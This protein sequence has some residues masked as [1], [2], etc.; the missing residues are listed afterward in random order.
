VKILIAEDDPVSS[1]VL[2]TTL[3]KWGHDV[4]T[5]DNGLNALAE[6]Q[7]DDAPRLA[8]LDWMMPGLEGPEVCRRLRKVAKT[9]PA[10]IILLTALSQKVQ[11]LAG[12]EAG[13]DD[14]LRKPFDRDELRVRLKVGVRTVELQSSL[15]QRV[16]ELEVAIAERRRA[17]EALRELTLTD[18]LTGLYNQRGFFTVAEHAL[19]TTRRSPH[20]SLLFYADL[21]GLKEINDTFGHSEGSLAIVKTAEAL[22]QTFRTTDIVARLGGDEFAIF[23]QNASRH[24]I[25]NVVAR[26]EANLR[27]VNEQP[28]QQYQLSLSVGAALIEPDNDLSLDQLIGKADRAMYVQKRS[29]SHSS[30]SSSQSGPKLVESHRSQDFP[31]LRL[32]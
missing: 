24:D 22:R 27:A 26:L 32:A 23:A 4:V 7:K 10:Y 2:A 12:L 5:T 21:D 17:E 15:V 18:N 31:K 14:Y 11:M 8:I 28:T 16:E 20:T 1:R 13:A 29:R 9:A 25:D 6:L 30:E 19:E 3:I